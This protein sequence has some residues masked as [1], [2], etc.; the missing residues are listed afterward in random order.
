MNTC[1]TCKHWGKP[2]TATPVRGSNRRCQNVVDKEN[3]EEAATPIHDN[4]YLS[5]L[6]TGPKF[7]CIHHE[8]K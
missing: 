3:A 6:Y 1:D 5:D 8:P 4:Y 2:A 7:G